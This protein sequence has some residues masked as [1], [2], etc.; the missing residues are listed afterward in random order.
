M[1][2]ESIISTVIFENSV[3]PHKQQIGR[4]RNRLTLKLN[5]IG[6]RKAQIQNESQQS[7]LPGTSVFFSKQ[8]AIENTSPRIT[9]RFSFTQ[10][11][12]YI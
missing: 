5:Q 9:K 10:T 8:S 6:H 11:G 7:I 12:E 2:G 3:M 1:V 4:K